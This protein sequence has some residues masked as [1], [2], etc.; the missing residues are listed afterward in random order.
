MFKHAVCSSQYRVC[1]QHT[2]EEPC[3]NKYRN[4]QTTNPNIQF[5]LYPFMWKTQSCTMLQLLRSFV[6]WVCKPITRKTHG[7]LKQLQLSLRKLNHCVNPS[8]RHISVLTQCPERVSLI[9]LALVYVNNLRHYVLIVHG[10]K[11]TVTFWK[12]EL[13]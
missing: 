6:S 3:F 10:N 13:V 2:N 12:I 1:D 7:K 8:L 4:N 11:I 9:T 5:V